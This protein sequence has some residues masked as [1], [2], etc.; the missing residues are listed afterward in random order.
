MLAT[1]SPYHVSTVAALQDQ[2]RARIARGDLP[3]ERPPHIYGG[4]GT[5]E[6]CSLCGEVIGSDAIEYEAPIKGDSFHF[7]ILCHAVWQRECVRLI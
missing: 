6:V 3:C 4:R 7:H 1:D 2:A 5:G